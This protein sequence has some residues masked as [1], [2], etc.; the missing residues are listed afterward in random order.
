MKKSII[1]DLDGTLWDTSN[2]VESVWNEVAKTYNLKME[3]NQIRKIMG[4]TKVEIID[5]FFQNNT[6]RGNAFIS[7]CQESENK[8]L[9][10]N[11]GHI[12]KNTI[13]TIKRLYKEYDLYIVSNCQFGYIDVFLEYYNLGQYFKDYECSGNTG[14]SKD[15]NIKLVVKRNNISNAIYVGDTEKDYQASKK[16]NLKFVWAKYG[17]GLCEKYDECIDDISELLMR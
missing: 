16:N 10:E 1:F 13:L 6:E 17:F 7:K 15:Y 9:L 12:Y 8:Y 14:K 2:E 3:N 4:L 11:G 5:Y